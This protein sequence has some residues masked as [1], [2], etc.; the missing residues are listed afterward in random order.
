M[1]IFPS[2]HLLIYIVQCILNSCSHQEYPNVILDD[3][4]G[5]AMNT[6]GVMEKNT[7]VRL[8]IQVSAFRS[9]NEFSFIFLPS[10]SCGKRSVRMVLKTKIQ[11][12]AGSEPSIFDN[13]PLF[14]EHDR[15]VPSS[16][17]AKVP[18]HLWRTLL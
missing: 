18:Q 5:F 7:V 15:C 17:S 8:A 9:F 1:G 13:L 11:M 12:L 14:Q 3:L 4:S 6:L 16:D 2:A 10:P